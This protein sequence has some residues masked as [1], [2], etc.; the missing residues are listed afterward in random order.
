MMLI[1]E[2][3]GLQILLGHP[4]LGES[5]L[6]VGVQRPIVGEGTQRWHWVPAGSAYSMPLETF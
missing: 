6:Q 3:M 5:Q 4:F 1:R 2:A